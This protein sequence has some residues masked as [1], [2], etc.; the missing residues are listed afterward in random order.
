[1]PQNNVFFPQFCRGCLGCPA[2]TSLQAG[3]SRASPA[4]RAENVCTAMAS[5]ESLA[6][7]AALRKFRKRFWKATAAATVMTRKPSTC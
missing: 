2:I 7:E 3:P 4:S 5:T 6:T 1:M